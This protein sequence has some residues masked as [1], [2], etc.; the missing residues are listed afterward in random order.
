LLRCISFSC[1]RRR[2]A[3]AALEEE[4]I[5]NP[6]LVAW[7][8]LRWRGGEGVGGYSTEQAEVAFR[9]RQESVMDGS[10]EWVEDED[11]EAGSRK[12]LIK[13]VAL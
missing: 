2:E 5:A 1:R 9:I 11:A 3:A 7:R 8:Y 4:V 10:E 12:S 6:A 13:R